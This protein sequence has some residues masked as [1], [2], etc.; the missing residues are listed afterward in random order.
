MKVK[1]FSV[2]LFAFLPRAKA[3]G[4]PAHGFDEEE[5]IESNR[6]LSS[7]VDQEYLYNSSSDRYSIDNGTTWITLEEFSQWSL[8]HNGAYPVTDYTIEAKIA[9]SL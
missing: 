7:S 2:S 1:L 9:H 4:F 8:D 5:E 6:I 3:R